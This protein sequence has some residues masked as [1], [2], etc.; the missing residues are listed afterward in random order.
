MR[1][2]VF[3]GTFDPVHLGHLILAE[4]CRE[5]AR[6]DQVFFIPAAS[7]PHKPAP[8]ITPFGHRVEMLS[9]ALAGQPAFRVN[10][11][12]SERPGPSYTADTLEE[13]HRRQPEAHLFWLI[14]A[15]ALPD[16]SCWH[17]PERI[18]AAA[19]LLVVGRPGFDL[20]PAERLRAALRL[21][22]QAAL[23]LEVAQMP[24][25]DIASRDLRRRAQE[26]R[27]LRYLVPRAVECYIQ[28]HRLYT[29][30]APPS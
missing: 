10:E 12:E 20:W 27:S 25:V 22:P 19:G 2:G 7:P 17:Q 28:T 15:D 11:L 9:L 8:E 6:L 1:L 30:S 4:Q 13:L 26:G 29:A 18:V 21:P 5:Q 24:L 23:R 14:G 3:G 16:L